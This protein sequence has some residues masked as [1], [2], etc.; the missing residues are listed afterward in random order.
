MR[1]LL[2]KD[3][4]LEA[5]VTGLCLAQV[6][7]C[8]TNRAPPDLKK[9]A[10][11]IESQK[12]PLWPCSPLSWDQH[13]KLCSWSEQHRHI[14]PLRTWSR[15]SRFLLH[16]QNNC[17]KQ[18]KF[19]LFWRMLLGCGLT[20]S[21]HLLQNHH[22]GILQECKNTFYCSSIDPG[23]N[24]R[25]RWEI[26]HSEEADLKLSLL[27]RILCTSCKRGKGRF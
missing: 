24:G 16:R 21:D 12:P 20:H 6:T 18:E 19:M 13:L 7:H 9:L 4:S 22:L 1:L 25:Q 11:D 8:P 23:K 5:A 26:C 14:L 17:L 2:I 27:K 3:A 10:L 15:L